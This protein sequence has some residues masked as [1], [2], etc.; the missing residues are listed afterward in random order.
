MT[1][2]TLGLFS[3]SDTFRSFVYPIELA[4][5]QQWHTT[6]ILLYTNI[7]SGGDL[8]SGLSLSIVS[9]TTRGTEVHFSTLLQLRHFRKGLYL[10]LLLM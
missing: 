4:S 8:T 1:T 10:V 6:L 9:I 5:G 2:A 7:S 3:Y